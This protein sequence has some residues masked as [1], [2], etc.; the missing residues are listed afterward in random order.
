MNIKLTN[1]VEGGS[2]NKLF[3]IS[4]SDCGQVTNSYYL[5]NDERDVMK[6]FFEHVEWDEEFVMETYQNIGWVFN[7]DWDEDE[8][9]GNGYERIE[10][11]ELGEVIQ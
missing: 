5:G 2:G 1:R 4:V 11:E 9:E 6:K 10:V 8:D 7:E 3:V